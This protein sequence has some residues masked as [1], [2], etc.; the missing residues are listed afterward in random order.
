MHIRVNDEEREVSFNLSLQDLIEY[1][2]L[3]PE[4]IAIELNQKVVRRPD[5]PVTHLQENDRVEIVHFV[6][7]GS[8]GGRRH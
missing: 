1:L 3:A 8:N 2:H 7:G 4:R 5:W 6:G